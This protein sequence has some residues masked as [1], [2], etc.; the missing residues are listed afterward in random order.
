MR[1]PHG[2]D[3][4]ALLLRQADTADLP[5]CAKKY[6]SQ[7]THRL[8]KL[9]RELQRSAGGRPFY[10]SCRTI[11]KLLELDRTSAARRLKM[12]AVDGILQIVQRGDGHRATRF[13]YIGDGAGTGHDSTVST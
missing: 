5:A 3:P 2:T 12:L 7:A 9:C 10:L 8:V 4:L 6:D 13:R 1:F 11:E